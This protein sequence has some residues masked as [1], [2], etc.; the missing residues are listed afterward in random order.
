MKARLGLFLISAL[1]YCKRERVPL[2]IEA[3]LNSALDSIKKSA[4]NSP[5]INWETLGK[6]VFEKVQDAKKRR[7]PTLQLR[8]FFIH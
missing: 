8:F 7:I 6:E 1:V 5:K 3:Y 2:K 4:L